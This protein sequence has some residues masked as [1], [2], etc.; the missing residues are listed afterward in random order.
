M[1]MRDF[2]KEPLV[3]AVQRI[4]KSTQF[5]GWRSNKW[6]G[7]SVQY[8]SRLPDRS[9]MSGVKAWH[10]PGTRLDGSHPSIKVRIARQCHS[11]GRPES[12]MQV[13]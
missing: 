2:D 13:R 5:E 10:C 4:I 7:S 8:V 12:L 3:R 9:I 6:D 11:G 1:K